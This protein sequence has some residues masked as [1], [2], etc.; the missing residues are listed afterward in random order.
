MGLSNIRMRCSLWAFDTI[1]LMG[2]TSC[3]FDKEREREIAHP[4]AISD[5]EEE[6]EGV[7]RY[8][9]LSFFLLQEI[10]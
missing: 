5:E 4:N 1:I 10:N 3:N 7:L 8:H 6:E 9:L 2:V